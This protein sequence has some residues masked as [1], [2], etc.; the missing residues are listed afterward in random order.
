MLNLTAL[1]QLSVI[2][3]T[4][5]TFSDEWRE[6]VVDY[7]INVFYLL[8]HL[9]FY[10]LG[11]STFNKSYKDLNHEYAMYQTFQDNQKM[12]K[13]HNELYEAQKVSYKLKINHFSD[14]TDEQ[15]MWQPGDVREFSK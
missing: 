14:M 11:K 1:V 6:F 15:I 2:L 12:I 4:N 5:I 8:W 7:L 3:S 10:F 13:E 9:L